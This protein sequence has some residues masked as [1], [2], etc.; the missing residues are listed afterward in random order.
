MVSS[1]TRVTWGPHGA[2]TVSLDLS[3]C[4]RLSLLGVLLIAAAFTYV[5]FIYKKPDSHSNNTIHEFGPM[6]IGL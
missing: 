2:N 3:L 5:T 4:R 1:G 6:H